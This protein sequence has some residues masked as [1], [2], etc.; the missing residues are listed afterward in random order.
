M[1]SAAFMSVSARTAGFAVFDMAAL[2]EGGRLVM[3]ALM[4]V[5]GAPGSTAGG[6]KL[7]TLVVLVFAI[8]AALRQREQVVVSRRSV[9]LGTVQRAAAVTALAAAVVF[10]QALLLAMLTGF[11]LSDVLFEATSAFAT[12]G[13]STGITPK[14]EVWARLVLV[15]GMF[16][17]R[18][19]P[20]TLAL[21]LAGSYSAHVQVRYPEAPVRIS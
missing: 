6:I 16:I 9:A 8:M 14:L 7:T 4:F 15:V 10:G 17:G 18:L 20:L 21:A 19:G 2:S 3:M 12:V 13:L 1:T 11:P 5:G